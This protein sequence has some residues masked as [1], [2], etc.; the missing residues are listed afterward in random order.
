MTS[1]EIK[2]E[3][4]RFSYRRRL[5]KIISIGFF[6]IVIGLILIVVGSL[7][8]AQE[9]RAGVAVGGFI[10]PIPFGFATNPVLFMAIL[11]VT[12]IIAIVFFAV[13]LRIV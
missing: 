7:V 11:A 4:R 3:P 8:D 13:S 1:G 5:P 2:G 10:G 12:V 6:A 9:N